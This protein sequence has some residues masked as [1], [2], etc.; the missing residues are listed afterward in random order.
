METLQSS[1]DQS[2]GKAKTIEVR[3]EAD[4]EKVKQILSDALHTVAQVCPIPQEGNTQ[5]VLL[6][7]YPRLYK[8]LP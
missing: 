8:R 1:L 2:G 7:S 4:V 5:M 6:P 3:T